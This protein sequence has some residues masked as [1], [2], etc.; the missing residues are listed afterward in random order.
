MSLMIKNLFIEG[1]DCS[2]KTTLIETIHK[3]TNYRYHINDRSQISRNI[4][5]N[6]YKRDIPNLDDD[7]R[8][9][10]FDLNNVYIVL[11]PPWNIV[12]ERFKKRGD[13]KHDEKSLKRVYSSFY[14][15]VLD[16]CSRF[17][18][19]YVIHDTEKDKVLNLCLDFLKFY[20]DSSIKNI[21]SKA[22]HI[23]KQCKNKEAINLKFDFFPH[24]SFPRACYSVMYHEKEREY[25][26]K[27]Y[28]KLF[29]KINAELNGE[30]E[31]CRKETEASRRFI[32]TDDTC[33]S[34]IHIMIRN[35]TLVFNCVI[36][37]S[38]VKDVL[39]H[40]LEFLYFL[41]SCIKDDFFND[42]KKIHMRFELN[43][44]HVLC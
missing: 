34:L 30:N 1:P 11:L 25:Y 10:M 12:L 19:V 17:P 37:S 14:G 28:N 32:Y 29:E 42:V 36:R 27:I 18:N 9:E 40:D 4:F 5:A 6:L 43:S 23:S 8:S 22:Y 15:P 7:L 21:A 3:K 24:K 33:I 13:E 20:Q 44:S 16:K 35:E 39:P 38:N 26:Q 31:Y 41:C 2:G